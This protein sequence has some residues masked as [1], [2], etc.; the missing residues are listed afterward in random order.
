MCLAA[1]KILYESQKVIPG[2]GLP[3][4]SFCQKGE[5]ALAKAVFLF[6]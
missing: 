2:F 3:N 4:S 6:L 1:V 5:R